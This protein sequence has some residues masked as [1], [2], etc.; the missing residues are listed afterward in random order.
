MAYSVHE[1]LAWP[2]RPECLICHSP[3]T[4]KHI[5]IDCICFSAARQRYLG[6]DTVNSK[7]FLKMSNVGNIV[8][9]I[10]DRPT[11]FYHCIYDVVFILA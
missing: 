1:G 3:L 2:N 11:N 5:V 9:F 6:V 7:N 4:V 8:D 10:K